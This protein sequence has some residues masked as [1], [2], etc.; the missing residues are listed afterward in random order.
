MMAPS[1]PKMALSGSKATHGFFM[2][3]ETA[4]DKL[5]RTLRATDVIMAMKFPS[6]S[7]SS[8]SSSSGG[9]TA[10]RRVCLRQQQ[11]VHTQE[12]VRPSVLSEPRPSTFQLR[13][14]R[15]RGPSLAATLAVL[16]PWGQGTSAKGATW[17][18][19]RRTS[20]EFCPYDPSKF[21]LWR[22]R[23]RPKRLSHHDPVSQFLHD[24]QQ[25]SSYPNYIE[26]ART[27]Q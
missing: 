12:T 2:T 17:Q 16:K 25:L 27:H 21:K 24:S 15:H 10:G 26:H 6:N 20:A 22:E 8:S 14:R 3:P 19:Q 4:C 18:E 5:A 13:K 11:L 7:S 9:R 1:G 23:L